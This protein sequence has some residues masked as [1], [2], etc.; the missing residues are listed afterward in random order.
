MKKK[1]LRMIQF[2]HAFLPGVKRHAFGALVH[3]NQ[4][5][6]EGHLMEGMRQQAQYEL[7]VPDMDS[8]HEGKYAFRTY[9]A[10]AINLPG[11]IQESIIKQYPQLSAKLDGYIFIWRF[12]YEDDLGN[13]W[14]DKPPEMMN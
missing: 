10:Q 14:A 2:S 5:D 9:E 13:K 11:P 12:F 8:N 1:K 4:A 3:K 7:A 6:D